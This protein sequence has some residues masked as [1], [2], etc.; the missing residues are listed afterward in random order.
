MIGT[1]M[2]AGEIAEMA[3]RDLAASRIHRG[4]RRNE[5]QRDVDEDL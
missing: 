1:S 2:I 4:E 5:T 3:A